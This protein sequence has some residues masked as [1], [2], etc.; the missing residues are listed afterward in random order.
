MHY[1]TGLCKSGAH[2]SRM[3]VEVQLY[4]GGTMEKFRVETAISP[5]SGLIYAELYY[6]DDTAT[7]IATTEPVYTG[8]QQ[9]ETDVINMFKKIISTTVNNQP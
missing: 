1:R 8:H 9:A 2:P 7:P 3:S 6:P 5:A 4:T